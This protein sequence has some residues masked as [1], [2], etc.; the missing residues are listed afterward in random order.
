MKI[1]PSL[2]GLELRCTS[3]RCAAKPWTS[4][5]LDYVV[6][7]PLGLLE[8]RGTYWLAESVLQPFSS[9]YVA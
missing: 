8:E 5:G 7:R 9:S 1:P 4:I 3:S 6:W 2:P